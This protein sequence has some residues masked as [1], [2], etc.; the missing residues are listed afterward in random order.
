MLDDKVKDSSYPQQWANRMLRSQKD[1][2]AA[3]S[4]ENWEVA[5][6]GRPPYTHCWQHH[7]IKCYMQIG[8]SQV[9]PT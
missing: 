5:R 3:A 1:E 9:P 7:L 8:R 2:Q 6:G 4:G